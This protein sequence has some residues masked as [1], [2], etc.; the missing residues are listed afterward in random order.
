ML[1]WYIAPSYLYLM[2]SAWQG[3]LSGCSHIRFLD[4]P[5]RF[6]ELRFHIP[7]ISWTQLVLRFSTHS[8]TQHCWSVWLYQK[9]PFTSQIDSSLRTLNMATPAALLVGP[10]FFQNSKWKSLPPEVKLKVNHSLSIM[11]HSYIELLT[12]IAGVQ[13]WNSR[14]LHSAL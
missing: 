7:C 1:L 8:T 9:F 3:C 5:L 11:S 12:S 14:W 13:N 10:L 2:Q 6:F 4:D